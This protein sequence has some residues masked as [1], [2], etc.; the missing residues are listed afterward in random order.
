M[1]TRDSDYMSFAIAEC[2][3]SKDK[4]RQTGCVFIRD[5]RFVAA[6]HNRFTRGAQELPERF[7]RPLKYV[8]T[9]HAE[10]IAIYQSAAMGISLSHTV[11]YIPWFPCADC[12]RALVE[13]ECKRLVCYEPDWNDP[14][15]NFREAETILKEGG[16][17][18]TYLPGTIG[19]AK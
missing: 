11:A 3:K 15:Y 5:G 10:R 1:P 17:I 2:R 13:V 18:I 14:K 7:E 19:E 4:S 9:E 6:G 8:F 16:V 12:A